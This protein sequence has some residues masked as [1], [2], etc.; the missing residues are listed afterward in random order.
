MKIKILAFMKHMNEETKERFNENFYCW[1]D[2]EAIEKW[3]EE[4]CMGVW[5][6]IEAAINSGALGFIEDVNPF[7]ICFGDV[8]LPCPYGKNNGY[9]L[10]KNS[11]YQKFF[12][13]RWEF[14]NTIYKE[15][16]EKTKE[17]DLDWLRKY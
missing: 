9:C 6:H 16:L 12:P 14:P 10:D 11:R 5:E 8:C 1:E 15:I 7:C 4:R 2:F 13:H 3:T 17:I